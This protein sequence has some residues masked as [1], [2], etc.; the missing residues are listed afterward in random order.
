MPL[1]ADQT[2][3]V[4]NQH[5][6]ADADTDQTYD[7]VI[8]GASWYNQLN[9]RADGGGLQSAVIAKV[10]IFAG[11]ALVGTDR[12][13]DSY[14]SPQDWD[15]QDNEG[16]A[17]HWTLR[18]GDLLLRGEDKVTILAVHDNRGARLNPHWYVEAH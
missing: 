1:V 8:S 16:R 15:T 2:I 3:T 18:P 7:T 5:Y 13:A 11:T 9:A 14:L 4:R 10:R 12:A 17:A 6:D